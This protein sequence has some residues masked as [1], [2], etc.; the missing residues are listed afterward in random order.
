[1]MMDIFNN[2]A[3]AA[4]E[5]TAAV[6]RLPYIPNLLGTY[7]ERLFPITRSRSEFVAVYRKLGKYALVPTSALGA[8]P[9]QYEPPP[10]DMRSFKVRR[11]AKASTV[12]ASELQ[13][14]LVGPEFQQVQNMTA[15]I[16]LRARAIKRDF[17]LTFEHMRMGAIVGQVVDA[18]GVTVLD[19]WYANWGV[20][21][22]TPINM[23]LTTPTTNVRAKALTVYDTMRLSSPGGFIP[24]QTVIHSLCGPTFYQLLVTHPNVEKFYMNWSAAKDLTAGIGEDF[25]FGSIMWHHFR[26]TDD[27]TTIAIPDDGCKFFP[28]GANE[29]FRR[30]QGPAE[31]LPF[32]NTPGRDTYGL[33]IVDDDRG[34]FQMT[35]LYS[36]PLFIC[37]RPEMLLVG[38]AS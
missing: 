38:T 27:G 9:V 7:G 21:P 17:E 4:V 26:G 19:D 20:T 6:D 25:T 3:F 36:Y 37:L 32:V 10:A 11:L 16:A 18:D 2:R 13:S 24:G 33:S 31:F 30:V 5:V 29:A 28:I 15:E 14:I 1:M 34:A 22:P 12:Y 35:E 23:Q 8:P